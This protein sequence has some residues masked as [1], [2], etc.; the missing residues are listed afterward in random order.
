[1]SSE[2]VDEKMSKAEAFLELATE[3]ITQGN[4]ALTDALLLTYREFMGDKDM[5][6]LWNEWFAKDFQC[7]FVRLADFV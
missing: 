2:V 5:V 7:V 4:S 3:A 6:A 1:M